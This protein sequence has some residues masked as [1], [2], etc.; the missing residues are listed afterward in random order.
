ML[1]PI[2][3]LLALVTPLSAVAIRVASFNVGAYFAESSGGVFYP[4]YG[5]GAAGTPDHDSVR[6][7]LGRIDADVV[8]LQEIDSADAAGSPNDVRDLA[9]S[10][11]YPHV[12]I[13]PVDASGDFK[14][15]FDSDLRVAILSR[16]PFLTTG[17]IRSPADARELT[18]LHAAV[19]VDVP[20]TSN[21]PVVITAH[22]KSGDSIDRFRRAVE[23]K[24]LAKHLNA[25]G[26]TDDDNYI[27]T[28]DFNLNPN[29]GNTTYNSLP[30]GLPGTYALGADIP[31]PVSYSVNPLAYFTTPG[32][33]RLDPRQLNGSAVTFP[34]GTGFTLD[35]M[36]VSPAIAGRVT[37]SEVYNSAL[38]VSNSGG[39]PKAGLPLAAG[40][41]ATASDHYAIF[42]DLELDSE[43]PD[44]A[45]ALSAPLLLEG[46]PDGTVNA[47]VTLPAARPAAVTVSLASDLPGVTPLSPARVI[48]AGSR[49]AVFALRA[50]RNFI[51]DPPRAVTFTATASGYDP[52]TVVLQ[53]EDV[54]G[55]YTFT[56][57]GATVTE[58]FSGFGGGHDPAPWVVS[59][60][61]AW[62]GAD[63]GTSPAAGWRAYGGPADPALGFL[64]AGAPAVATASF[65]NGSAAPLTALRIAF[66]VEQWR[67]ALG[68]TA[69]SLSADLIVNG[70]AFPLPGLFHAASTSL[71]S[72]AVAGGLTTAKSTTVSGISIP[73]GAAFGLRVTFTPGSG[74]GV[75]SSE[76]F[77]N[78]FHYDNLDADSGEFLEVVVAPGFSQPV[79]TLDVV[80][81]NGESAAGATV[82]DTLNLGSRFT[83]AGTYEGYRI[84]T[85]ELPVNGIQNGPR[86]GFAIVNTTTSE[87]LQLVSYEGT[88]T[89]AAGT[90]AAGMTSVLIGVSQTNSTAPASSL[91]LTGSGG[92]AADFTWAVSAGSNTKGAL[93]AGQTFVPPV[94]PPQ[95]LAIDNLGVTALADPDS[96]GDGLAD[97]VD[98]DDDNDGQSDADEI[99]FGTDPLDPSSFFKPLLTRA[100][101]PA[102]GYELTFPAAVGITYRVEFSTTLEGW[103]ELSTHVG[104]GQPVSVPLPGAEPAM[105]YRVRAGG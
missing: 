83:L 70:Q 91:G 67:A 45:L 3:L 11:G 89:A 92:V 26:L 79:S 54:D 24:R 103:E 63:S 51:L 9:A 93:N 43:Q 76:V 94:L 12:Y 59:G 22:L 84:F 47:T 102:H 38:D 4:L 52:D 104:A 61:A 15:P 7:I 65:V 88:F 34:G 1:K 81:Y 48:P 85:V 13:A 2:V 57:T 100:A 64:P 55:P 82:Y 28:G 74:G 10:L 8:A 20:G 23:M 96:D 58:N 44:L 62:R 68:G 53:L 77:L 60:G 14:A 32:I 46:L 97:W 66:D 21:D 19:K 29:Y 50:P 17:A 40:T 101:V 35:L 90:P 30:A 37:D 39:L 75:P 72:G 69:D 86:D 95:G 41:S 6:A 18:R 78:E 80:L 33:A 98:S 49:S 16:H 5:L 25:L 73:P 27:I 31:F 71:P 42:A 87:V 99:A 36:L 56:A 105:F